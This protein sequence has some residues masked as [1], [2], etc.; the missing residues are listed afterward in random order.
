MSN[1]T[2]D[3]RQILR[4]P[5]WLSKHLRCLSQWY[6]ACSI[7]AEKKLRPHVYFSECYSVV[8]RWCA[9][10]FAPGSG[11]WRRRMSCTSQNPVN[12]NFPTDCCGM[13][14]PSTSKLGPCSWWFLFLRLLEEV[15]RRKTR[16]TWREGS[17]GALVGVNTELCG[18]EMVYCL[19]KCLSLSGNCM[20]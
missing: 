6:T 17:W 7:L 13:S 19:D 2:S 15:I 8:H 20:E 3:Y 14:C 12:N 18:N 16:L 5:T 9:F 4:F 1:R 10:I 11:S